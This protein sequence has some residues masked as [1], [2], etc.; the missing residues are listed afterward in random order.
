MSTRSCKG[1]V[2]TATRAPS[3][4]FFSVTLLSATL[5][6]ALLLMQIMVMVA[7]HRGREIRDGM[8]RVGLKMGESGCCQHFGRSRIRTIQYPDHHPT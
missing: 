6:L 2:G 1:A 7:V 8:A 4:A 5:L 3:E